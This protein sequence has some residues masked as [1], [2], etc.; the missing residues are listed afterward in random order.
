LT[1]LLPE[2]CPTG[3]RADKANQQ[4]KMI[5]EDV[6]MAATDFSLRNGIVTGRRR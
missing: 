6:L 5:R 4:E 1:A 2:K 3:V